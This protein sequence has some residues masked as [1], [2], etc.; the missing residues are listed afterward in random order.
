MQLEQLLALAEAGEV[1]MLELHSLEGFYLLRIHGDG[2]YRWLEDSCGQPLHLRSLEHARDLLVEL[3]QQIPFH[4]VQASAYDEMCG[5]S[6][7]RREPL[8]VAV[9]MHPQW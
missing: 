6:E 8:R 9:S 4:L 5:L 2:N 3:R 7:G 1:D